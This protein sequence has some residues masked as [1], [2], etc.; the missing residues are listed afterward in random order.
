MRYITRGDLVLILFLLMAS[1]LIIILTRYG[2]LDG[3]YIMVI[4]DN[5]T[6]RFKLDER[7]IIDA[8]G[9]LGITKIEIREGKVRI[10]SSPCKGKVCVG[11]GWARK[12]G[13]VVICMPNHV[14]V[15]ILKEVGYDA[16]SR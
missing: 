2:S 15:R 14:Q 16:V 10:V 11:Y 12:E 4:T 3:S 8:E 7:R 6:K 5:G 13:E 1:G 9:P